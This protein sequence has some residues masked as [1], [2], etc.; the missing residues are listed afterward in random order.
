MDEC[1]YYKKSFYDK[2]RIKQNKEGLHFYLIN[3]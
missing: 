3:N 1:F 2:T